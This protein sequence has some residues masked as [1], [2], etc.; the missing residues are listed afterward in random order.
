MIFYWSATYKEPPNDKI[1]L[2]SISFCKK[3][4]EFFIEWSEL[5]SFM[6]YYQFIWILFPVYV[7][8][9]A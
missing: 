4:L 1:E 5:R 3:E 9:E 6:E 8:I 2:F 7:P